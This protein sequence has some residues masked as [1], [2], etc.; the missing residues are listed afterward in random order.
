MFAVGMVLW[1][2]I[3]GE[4]M[5]DVAVPGVFAGKESGSA[6]R[7]GLGVAN[8]LGF[9]GWVSSSPSCELGDC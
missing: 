9:W 2:E 8:R 1:R 7:S 5:S 3:S 6:L 4:N